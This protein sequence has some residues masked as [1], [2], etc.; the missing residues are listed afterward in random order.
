[1]LANPKTPDSRT[2]SIA[3]YALV[4]GPLKDEILQ[5]ITDV[6]NGVVPRV[7]DADLAGFGIYGYQIS[8][9][10]DTA[11]VELLA[12]SADGAV[13]SGGTFKLVWQE[14]D[15]RVDP[16]TPDALEASSTDVKASDFV[17]WGPTAGGA[18]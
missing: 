17:L 1:M 14:G 18:Q 9:A 13:R 12:G 4:D 2:R 16:A 7:T 15:W 10:G 5:R 6:E 3:E 8:Y 11:V